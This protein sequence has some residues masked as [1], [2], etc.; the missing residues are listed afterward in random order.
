MPESGVLK[1]NARVRSSKEQGQSQK[2]K[3]TRA[4]SEVLLAC[5]ILFDQKFCLIESACLN[6]C[7]ICRF[8]AD[9]I[10]FE[11]DL[12]CSDYSI[13]VLL[14]KFCLIRSEV[15]KNKIIG[16]FINFG[17]FQMIITNSSFGVLEW[18]KAHNAIQEVYFMPSFVI[19]S[20]K[21][22]EDHIWKQ[23]ITSHFMLKNLEFF[24]S[25]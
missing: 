8:R 3:R 24:L 15:L 6:W 14:A 16:H 11:V 25:V 1:N 10:L 2:F 19:K 18:F 20:K 17:Q 13:F 5:V 7:I 22:K 23:K 21:W 9:L 12:I 4:E